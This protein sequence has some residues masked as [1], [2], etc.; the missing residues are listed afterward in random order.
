AEIVD[1]HIVDDFG[2]AGRR[3]DLDLGDMRAVRI[4]AVGAVE[5]GAAVELRGVAAGAPGEISE[6][7]RAVGAGDAD[8][9]VADLE[10][11]GAGLQRLR[12]QLLQLA[13]EIRR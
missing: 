5:R 7:D 6:A 12:R 2:D 8:A 11:A 9:A 13:A 4:G 1:D 3:T 10:V